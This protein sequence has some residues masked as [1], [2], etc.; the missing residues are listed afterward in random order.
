MPKEVKTR[1]LYEPNPKGAAPKVA[2][3]T[4]LSATR[5]GTRNWP[6]WYS[7]NA[8]V[9]YSDTPLLVPQSDHRIDFRRP[10]RRYVTSQNRTGPQNCT[11]ANEGQ[12][13]SRPDA[14]K[15]VGH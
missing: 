15:Q 1:T 4:I 2:C 13:I 9:A 7:T 14:I 6:F 8:P 11:D 3:A 5:P 12:R 10:S